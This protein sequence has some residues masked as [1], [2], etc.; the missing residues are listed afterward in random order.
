[1]TTTGAALMFARGRALALDA[2]T[3]S[4]TGADVSFPR[5]G[6]VVGVVTVRGRVSAPVALTGSSRESVTLTGSSVSV[7]AVTGSIQ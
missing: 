6:Q 4:V 5:T 2:A 1:V 3:I 7:C